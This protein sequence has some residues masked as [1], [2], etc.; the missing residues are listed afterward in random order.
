MKVISWQR[1]LRGLAGVSPSARLV[2]GELARLADCRGAAICSIDFLVDATGRDRATVF[3]AL[4]QL[5]ESGFLRRHA[6]RAPTHQRASLFELRLPVVSSS[7]PELASCAIAL[8]TGDA[9]PI[10]RNDNEG[11]RAA[12]ADA[13]ASDWHGASAQVVGATL[14]AEGPRQFWAAVRHSM[15]CGMTFDEALGDT[16]ATAWQV[17][18][19]HSG[20]LVASRRPWGLWT[21]IVVK[22]GLKR[23]SNHAVSPIPVEPALLPET[24]G[25]APLPVDRDQW[26]ALD[27]FDGPLALIVDAL[28]DAGMDETIAWA[29]TLRVA[30][31]ACGD[32]GRRH[33]VAGGD[34]RL[35]DLG[36]EPG[37]A[38]AWMTLLVGSR[39][40]TTGGV[41]DLGE[42]GLR[43]RCVDLV[44]RWKSAA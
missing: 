26:V 21:A 35:A 40:G 16:I 22:Q 34:S 10:G 28:V 27:D 32:P 19:E 11:L 30:E 41:L 20:E 4:R 44:K 42:E 7:D 6:R 17:V 37:V 13:Q 43:D 24:P 39:R 3:R 36:V 31:I 12:L 18:R 14:V 8:E 1:Q 2:L 5:E 38:R 9:T 25:E 33:A 29:G 15:S 23:D